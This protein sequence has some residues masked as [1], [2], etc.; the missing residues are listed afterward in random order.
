[1]AQ[2][3]AFSDKRVL[4]VANCES[5]CRVLTRVFSNQ[6]AEVLTESDGESGLATVKRFEPHVVIYSADVKQKSAAWF[7]HQIRVKHVRD[8]DVLWYIGDKRLLHFDGYT[9]RPFKPAVLIKPIY[10]N[11]VVEDDLKRV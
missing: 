10:Y 6:G 2:K 7:A 8:I 3:K 1:M 9:R 4:I 5:I 11:L